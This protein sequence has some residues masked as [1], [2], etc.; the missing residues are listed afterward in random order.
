MSTFALFNLPIVVLRDLFQQFGL[1]EIFNISIISRRS[2]RNVELL[3]RPGK[4]LDLHLNVTESSMISV[5]RNYEYLHVKVVEFA[6][7]MEEPTAVSWVNT[8]GTPVPMAIVGQTVYLTDKESALKEVTKHI[9]KVFRCEIQGVSLGDSCSSNM[10]AWV[11]DFVNS[12]QQSIKTLW[13]D[14]EDAS[15]EHLSHV[16]KK[17]QVSD[18]LI[19]S[20]QF[21][22]KEP[23]PEIQMGQLS[24]KTFKNESSSWM[25]IDHLLSLN[26][27]FGDLEE[28]S[29]RSKD[30]NTFLKHWMSGGCDRLQELHIEMKGSINVNKVLREIDFEVI[31]S[32]DVK[33]FDSKKFNDTLEIRGGVQVCRKTDG[34]VAR[35]FDD[36]ADASYFSF[37]VFE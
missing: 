6:E 9:S 5:Q 15:V 24:M 35:L 12:Q 13:L 21:S 16:L 30:I 8:N 22:K 10:P 1:A 34:K 25:T 19:C 31:S 20:L 14:A 33:E 17:A 26:F 28:T 2:Q 18:E 11:I 29:L 36:E 32:G 3:M 7:L 27:E 23:Y 37:Y 4:S